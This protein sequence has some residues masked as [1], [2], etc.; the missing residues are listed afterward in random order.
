MPDPWWSY[1]V[2]LLRGQA[3][4]LGQ[5]RLPGGPASGDG[6]GPGWLL[7]VGRPHHPGQ[8]IVLPPQLPE[9]HTLHLQRLLQLQDSDLQPRTPLSGPGPLP[10]GPAPPRSSAPGGTDTGARRAPG[11]GTVGMDTYLGLHLLLLQLNEGQ[12]GEVHGV[13]GQRGDKRLGARPTPSL[14]QGPALASVLDLLLAG[15]RGGHHVSGHLVDRAGALLQAAQV[16]AVLVGLHLGARGRGSG[17]APQDRPPFPGPLA[18]RSVSPV[19]QRPEP[20]R[21]RSLTLEA[22]TSWAVLAAISWEQTM[23]SSYLPVCSTTLSAD[24]LGTDRAEPGS[25]NPWGAGP[26]ARSLLPSTRG[27]VHQLRGPPAHSLGGRDEAFRPARVLGVKFLLRGCPLVVTRGK[28]GPESQRHHLR[29][30]MLTAPSP[31][32]PGPRQ[33]QG[34]SCDSQAHGVH[35]G[36]SRRWHFR[37]LTSSLSHRVEWSGMTRAPQ[38]CPL[39]ELILAAGPAAWPA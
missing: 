20:S 6:A 19:H 11:G 10:R 35:W 13:C 29:Q 15:L 33:H 12:A 38:S 24:S 5:R 31:L 39:Q 9:T 37:C 21:A 27:D 32:P 17:W 34:F 16:G 4:L 14:D 23:S 7:L 1:L 2:V 25:L 3:G 36:V 30:W 28:A 8:H 18:T 22:A 26:P